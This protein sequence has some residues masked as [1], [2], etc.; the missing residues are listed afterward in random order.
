M[1]AQPRSVHAEAFRMLRTNLEFVRLDRDVKTIMVTSAMQLE[2]KSTTAANLAIALARSGQRVA[3]I[4]LD[5]RR[6]FLHKFFDLKGPGVTEVA[7]GHVT[8]DQ[9]IE[10]IGFAAFTDDITAK[11]TNGS[12]GNG[13]GNGNGWRR[14][15]GVLD[16]LASGPLPPDPGEF[17]ATDALATV[18]AELRSRYDTVIIDTPPVIQ[19]GDALTLSKRADA[20]VVVA[21]MNV[22]RRHT[23]G[24]LGRVL[25]TAPAAKLG[26]VISGAGG[27]DGQQYGYYGYDGGEGYIPAGAS[28]EAEGVEE[29]E[30][31]AAY[32]PAVKEET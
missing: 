18:L 28:R 1:L 29:E 27:E 21:R 24:E 14:V 17:V 10:S 23:L 13:S 16:V 7:M 2:G 3:L 6:P 31:A 22:A 4:D 9:A 11:S 32:R 12:S 20:I 8:L 30:R 19:V 5:L 25:A 15:K 26:F